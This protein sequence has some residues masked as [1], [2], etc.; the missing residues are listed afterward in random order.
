MSS[1][2]P[3]VQQA[4][5]MV[6]SGVGFDI[7]AHDF[8]IANDIWGP[9]I[10]SLEGKTLKMGAVAADTMIAPII[11]QQDQVLSIDVMFVDLQ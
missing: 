9:D 4:L 10:A 7:T 6:E 2:M 3:P 8:R 5:A 11:G 1:K